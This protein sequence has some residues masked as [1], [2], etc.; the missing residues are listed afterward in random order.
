MN[1]SDRP[2]EAELDRLRSSAAEARQ[3][4]EA[5]LQ[6][7]FERAPLG[8]YLVD[9]ELRISKVNPTARRAFAEIPELIGRE[10]AEVMHMLWEP[11]LADELVERFSHTLRT[12]EPYVSPE[13]FAERRDRG[14]IECYEWQIDRIP[15]SPG[16][17]GVVCYFRDVSGRKRDEDAV[18]RAAE[19]DA[20]RVA[21]ADTLR[22]LVDPGQLQTEATRMLGE[23][24]HATRVFYCEVLLGQEDAVFAH[25][26]G[27]GGAH[28]MGPLR[29]EDYGPST[30]RT[31]RSGQR[32][33]VADLSRDPTLTDEERVANAAVGVTAHLCVPL[34]KDGRLAGFLGVSQATP[35]QWTGG[36]VALVEETAERMW[37]AI[38]RARAEAALREREERLRRAIGIETVG[39]IFV[40]PAGPIV[41][42][43]DAF[44]RMSGY[45]REDLL[46]G[47]LR[48]DVMTPPEFMAMSLQALEQL[49]TMGRTVP[50]VKQH[51]RKDG[52]R[53]WGLFAATLLSEG[54]GVEFIIDVTERK[55]AEEALEAADRH[56]DEF[57][58]TLSH[59]LRNPLA[60]IRH[61]LTVL[62]AAQDVSPG[63]HRLLRMMDRQVGNLVR[64]VD[65]LLEVSRISRGKIE[66]RTESVDVRTIVQSAI[67]TSR[68]LI[69]AAEHQ[70]LVSLPPAPLMVVADPLRLSQV[71]ANL[72]NNAA[73][74]TKPGGRIWLTVHEDAS[75]VVLS[76]RDDGVG[77]PPHV[78]PRIFEMFMQM[79]PDHKRAQ[80]GLGIGLAVVRKLVEMHGGTVEARSAGPGEGSELVVRLPGARPEPIMT[81][82]A[83]PVGE[84]AAV[85]EPCRARDRILVVDDNADAAAAL[86][87]LLETMGHD[88]RVALD[89]PSALA[90]VGSQW[91]QV[92][93]LDLG[94]PGMSGYEVAHQL[95]EDPACAEIT[96]VALTG[97]GQDEDRRRTQAA[98]FHHHLVKPVGLAT[99]E[100]LLAT[101]S[102]R[103]R[104]R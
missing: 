60:P 74:Y 49:M 94:M 33:V 37:A 97:W 80:G 46:E 83:A 23:H 104:A 61:A 99:L 51:I 11:E 78:L 87:M 42:A 70:L 55:L 59:E 57:L 50:Y 77:I 38:Q 82:E 71:M 76:V 72:L 81:V 4:S 25:C 73:K 91:P 19:A 31:L 34:V 88:V 20:F 15:L 29:L 14:T 10:L 2:S 62:E 9:A 85:R 39:V 65:D 63:V 79:D 30:I 69:D 48:W 54:E 18:R 45:T 66:L 8:V 101:V 27:D 36:E 22:S 24:L 13:L 40:Q 89:G 68:P 53:W 102:T 52:S 103:A 28:V 16:R 43:N 5:Q 92:V 58:A 96:L 17:E 1:D 84:P 35:R 64:M 6:T 67:E 90:V 93:L 95:R 98:G 21:L 56:K 75:D 12:G 7:L 41:E 100:E 32:V 44:L 47:A 86:G 3:A 26:F